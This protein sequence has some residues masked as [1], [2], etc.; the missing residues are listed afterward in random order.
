MN[1][2]TVVYILLLFLISLL[3]GC[4]AFQRDVKQTSVASK[5][6]ASDFSSMYNPG[7][8]VVNPQ[9]TAFVSSDSEAD[10]FFR[11]K[12]QE[13]RNALANPLEKEINLYV[14]Y[15]LRDADD[16]HLVDTTSM[17]YTF[18]VS[19]GEYVHGH[20]KVA[21]A[22]QARYKLVVDF[23]NTHYEIRKRL[24]CDLKN[25]VGFNDDKYIVKT[26]SDDIVFSNVATIG[27]KLRVFASAGCASYV[28]VE[29]YGD[30]D[31]IPIPPYLNSMSKTSNFPDSVF[32]YMFG[33][34][35]RLDEVGFYAFGSASKNE[36]FGI[37]VVDN[38][39]YPKVTRV[40]D[41]LEPMKLLCTERE[42]E[43]IDTSA[44]LKREIDAFWLGLSKNEKSAK[45]Q[46]RV[47]YSRVAL[48]NMLF[49]CRD[50][51]WRTDRGM[52]YIMLGP[53][54]VVNIT[55]SSEEWSY[56]GGNGTVFT[57]ENYSGI[58]NDF[59]LLRSNTYQSVWQQVLTTWR[60]GKIF[61]VSKLNN[62]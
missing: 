42:Y 37:A 9:M 46:I 40:T 20:F 32:R 18:D 57:F 15:Y 17:R 33:D 21:L 30:R 39:S 28:D 35:L 13:L 51:G 23:V 3:G 55:P 47:F 41:M 27:Q 53:P 48:A 36:K 49:S 12:T 11:I 50:E 7:S 5:S 16:F 59:T 44:N 45:E 29:F 6:N 61:T 25:T 31:Y 60:S 58:K 56:G 8:S 1:I 14:R 38:I 22:S 54:S 10:V 24:L 52:I 62:E 26:L 4:F 34:T 2:R 19:S 43:R